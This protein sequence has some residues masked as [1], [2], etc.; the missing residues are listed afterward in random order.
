MSLTTETEVQRVTVY[1][2]SSDTWQ[3]NNLASVPAG[4]ETF[5]G[6]VFNIEPGIVHLGS[7]IV[8][9]HP[10]KVAGIS[11]GSKCL[12]LHILHATCFGGGPNKPGN[13]LHVPDGTLIGQYVIHYSDGS[14]EDVT[15]TAQ[16]E[17]ND[18]DMAEITP[19]GRVKIM[20]RP[21]DVAA[22]LSYAAAGIPGTARG[23]LSRD[24]LPCNQQGRALAHPRRSR[25]GHV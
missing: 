14:S 17:P 23:H 1:I 21:G 25:R 9:R 20:G 3:G 18:K 6:I 2:G 13:Q 19:S 8:D 7:T 22:R 11:V 16:Y 10:E 24:V 4:G 12:K 15:S 5:G